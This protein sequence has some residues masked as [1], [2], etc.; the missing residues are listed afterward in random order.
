LRLPRHSIK[1]FQADE[2]RKPVSM[3][4][5]PILSTSPSAGRAIAVLLWVIVRVVLWRLVLDRLLR[6]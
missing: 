5:L 4:S 2:I 3:E 1:R 6:R